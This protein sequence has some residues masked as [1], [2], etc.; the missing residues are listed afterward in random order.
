MTDSGPASA[1]MVDATDY[2]LYVVTAASDDEVSGCLVGFVRQCSIEPVRFIVCVSK[3][4]HTFSVVQRASGLALHLLGSDQLDLASLFGQES[5]DWEDK[6]AR[7]SWKRGTTLA[8]L[9]TESAAWV[10]GPI[11]G[12]WSAG[13]HQAFVIEITAGAGGS[14]R[15]CL[16]QSD[17]SRLQA[18]HP[19]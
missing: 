1:A 14:H 16:M 17:A 2:A 15:A 13:D 3:A 6:F 5:G 18:G 8:P 7:V 10:E 4:N 19:G 11:V 9:L 12:T